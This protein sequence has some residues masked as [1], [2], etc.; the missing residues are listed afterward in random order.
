P[1]SWRVTM[2]LKAYSLLASASLCGFLVQA[3]VLPAHAQTLTGQVSS[4]EEGNMEGVLVT[5]KRD[6]ATVAITVV[7]D[8][9]GQY[10]F[11]AD[12][13]AHRRRIRAG[14]HP[15][16]ALLARQPADASAAAVARPARRASRRHRRRRQGRRRIS[17]QHLA[18]QSGLDG[19]QL[20]DFSTPDRQVD[21]R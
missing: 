17:R 3:G 19:V 15:D 11:P 8:A 12:L 10:N 4:A 6:G 14:V 9:K 18:R 21:A 7:T 1:S 20:Q 2:Q 13:L 5:A 16:V